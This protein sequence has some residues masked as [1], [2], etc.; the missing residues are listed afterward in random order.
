MDIPRA[1]RLAD[2]RRI[3][4][5][6]PVVGDDLAGQV[7]DRPA[8]RIAL[9]GVGVDAPVAPVEIFVDGG[10]DVDDRLAVGPRLPALLAIKT[11]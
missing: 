2:F 7:E 10:G 1:M 5:R 4:M 3:D 11:I 8:K 9:I 6:Q